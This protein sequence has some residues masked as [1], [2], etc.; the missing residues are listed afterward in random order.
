MSAT[1]G[2]MREGS[3][4]GGRSG[5]GRLA[6]NAPSRATRLIGP[7]VDGVGTAS[8]TNRAA[9]GEATVVIVR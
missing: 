2:V 3:A 4:G 7:H 8:L 5:S 6:H 9:A 1:R